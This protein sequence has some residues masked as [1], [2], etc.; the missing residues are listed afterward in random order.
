MN[1]S[2]M[3]TVLSYISR[4]DVFNSL[5]APFCL[6]PQ[7][8]WEERV[9]SD[10]RVFYIDHS[11]FNIEYYQTHL[12]VNVFCYLFIYLFMASDDFIFRHQDHTMG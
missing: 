10:G 8:G 7:P 12:M 1:S 4:L 11:A 2:L 5:N 9:H 3:C 6:H